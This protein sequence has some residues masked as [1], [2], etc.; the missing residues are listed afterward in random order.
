MNVELFNFSK[1]FNS[2]KVP[3][4]GSGTTFTNVQLK[5]DCSIYTPVLL[6]AVSSFSVPTIAPTLYNYA[7]IGKFQRNYFIED[8]VYRG[9]VWEAQLSIDVLGTYKTSIGLISTMVER[10]YTSYDGNLSDSKYPMTTNTQIT[11]IAMNNP[12]YQTVLSN[13]CFVIGITGEPIY[14]SDGVTTY[15]NNIG[16]IN[17]Y[18]IGLHN[19]QKLC[20]WLFSD[21]IW[22]T[23]GITDISNGLFQSM[24]NPMQYIVSCVW[25]PIQPFDLSSYNEQYIKI[26]YW[27]TTCYG[28]PMNTYMYYDTIS[29]QIPDHPQIARGNYLNFNPYT[30]VTAYLPVFGSIPVDMSFRT[31][32]SYV[33]FRLAVDVRSGQADCRGMIGTQNEIVNSSAD[34][35]VFYTTS[36]MFGV[37]IQL[38]QALTE[39]ISSN[40]FSFSDIINPFANFAK[41]F[42]AQ[43][44]AGKLGA[45]VQY[46]GNYPSISSVGSNGSFLVAWQKATM[47]VEHFKI[48]DE[49]R[50]EFGRPLLQVKTINTLSG[51]VKCVDA[52]IEL[53]ITDKEKKAITEFM[54][55]GFFYE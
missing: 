7:M 26:G 46:Q 29:A 37:P 4:S 2:T 20:K 14:Q 13:G 51:Y 30:K 3:T 19:M 45:D 10:S 1:R 16:S 41:S 12:F 15:G 39:V 36:G 34:A 33:G 21:D 47:I 48:T 22:N 28:Y 18:A 25:L 17:Y 55:S 32:G 53:P 6:F 44:L 9:N 27:T 24:F 42:G 50:A 5:D 52:H 8:W 31:S 43:W 38:S 35:S 49:D 11:R 54:N 23:S 40:G